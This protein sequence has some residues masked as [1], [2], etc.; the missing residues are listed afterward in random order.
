MSVDPCGK[1][2]SQALR[3]KVLTSRNAV[4]VGI[5]QQL[6]RC[7]HRSFHSSQHSNQRALLAHCPLCPTVFGFAYR[8][9]VLGCDNTMLR[10]RNMPLPLTLEEERTPLL[11]PSS[12]CGPS[13]KT[14]SEVRGIGYV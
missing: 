14:L 2:S 7:F 4:N 12:A 6:K 8:S 11:G 10:G 9:R 5:F 1:L 3:R 13:S